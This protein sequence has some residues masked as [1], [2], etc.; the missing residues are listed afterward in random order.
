[1]FDF[2]RYE[3]L[4]LAAIA[5]LGLIV[6]AVAFGVEA[7]EDFLACPPEA[8]NG[9]TAKVKAPASP[10]VD[11]VCL[12]K[13]GSAELVDALCKATTPNAEVEIPLTLPSPGLGH[14]RYEVVAC[15]T[16]L[17]MCSV[18]AA[19]RA[20]AVDIDVPAFSELLRRIFGQ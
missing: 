18:P 20:I 9:C 6:G 12:R 4:H 14:Q 11:R 19:R 10:E 1:M 13:V 7:Q 2:N 8:V 5:V 15:D 3:K 16:E 17:S